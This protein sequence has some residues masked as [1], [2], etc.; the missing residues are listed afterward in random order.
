MIMPTEAPHTTVL[1]VARPVPIE[2]CTGVP[3]SDSRLDTNQGT[4]Q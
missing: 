3:L 1:T 2:V 4:I